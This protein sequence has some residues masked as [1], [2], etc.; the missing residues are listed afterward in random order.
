MTTAAGRRILTDTW[1]MNIRGLQRALAAANAVRDGQ[2]IDVA[3]LEAALPSP[4]PK[5]TAPLPRAPARPL[6]ETG[7]AQRE[8]LVALLAKHGGNISAVA[9]ELG[10]AR[11]QVRRWIKRYQIG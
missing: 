6:S 11:F 8:Q 1:P 3:H 5:D 9:R 7:H 2:M 4:S 10:K